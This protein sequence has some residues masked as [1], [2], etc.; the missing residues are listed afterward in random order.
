MLK[1]NLGLVGRDARVTLSDLIGA[2]L[3]TSGQ[4]LVFRPTRLKRFV[5]MLSLDG[6]IQYEGQAFS[7]LSA[8]AVHVAGGPYQPWSKTSVNGISLHNLRQRLSSALSDRDTPKAE[9]P[10]VE[11][12]STNNQ[13]VPM[14]NSDINDKLRDRL[15]KLSPSEFESLLGEYF[16]AKGFLNVEVTGRSN[17]GGIDGSCQ[18]P[19]LNLKIAF[20]AKRYSLGNNIGIDPVQRLSGS[21]GNQYHRGVFVTTSSFTQPAIGWVQ[22]MKAPITLVDGDALVSDM[23]E[24]GLG[25][26]NV[27]VV[28]TRLD[29]E[30][31]RQFDD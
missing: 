4:E 11:P 18:I 15:L 17:D 21:L 1:G 26:R 25:V 16:S 10:D 12:R 8:W 9:G 28:E 31:F 19:F 7:S 22:E 3:L 29:E 24:L 30:F 5:G 20:Q 27:P 13:T 23:I 2:G 14:S 6:S